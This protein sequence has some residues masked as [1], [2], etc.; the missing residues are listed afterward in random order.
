MAR[1][2][3]IHTYLSELEIYLSRIN[4][5][6]A[7]EI[8]KEIE[9]HIYDSLM[10]EEDNHDTTEVVLGR[11]GTPQELA[12]VYIEHI[13][14][15][16]APPKGLKPMTKITMEM[17]K[18]FYYLI[19]VLGGSLGLSLIATAL[20]KLIVPSK[21]G[22]WIAEHGNSII[23]SFSNNS[24]H[25]KEIPA[26]WLVPISLLAGLVTLYLTKRLTQLLKVFV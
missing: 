21:F 6:Q 7:Q 18:S 10:M 11:L 20:A 1:N 16:V 12:S 3:L 5:V 25:S 24:Y 19:F 13:N 26:I 15:G 8:V 4:K 17:S 22:V 23:V 9:S 2:E 14:I